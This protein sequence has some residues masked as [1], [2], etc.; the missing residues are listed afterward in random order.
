[1][2]F[3]EFYVMLNNNEYGG[4]YRESDRTRTITS[5]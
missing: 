1:M 4:F 2:I 5:L 3:G